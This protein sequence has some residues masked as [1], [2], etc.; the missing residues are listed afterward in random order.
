MFTFPFCL[1]IVTVPFVSTWNSI[2]CGRRAYPG[3]V[4]VSTNRYLPPGI[5]VKLAFPSFPV[6]MFCTGLSGLSAS[7][8]SNFTFSRGVSLLDTL[9]REISIVCTFRFGK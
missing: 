4:A 2:G 3:A 8:R 9:F 1:S 5:T 6:V 7:Y